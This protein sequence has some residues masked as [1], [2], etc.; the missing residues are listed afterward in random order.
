MAGRLRR[1]DDEGEG[2][3]TRDHCAI[4]CCAIDDCAIWRRAG[5]ALT[6][7]ARIPGGLLLLT[8]P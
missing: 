6:A 3:A 7:H 8:R 5:K 2:M 1:G 4:G